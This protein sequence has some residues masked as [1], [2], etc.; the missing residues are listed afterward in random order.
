MTIRA[1]L[2]SELIKSVYKT[3]SR[4]FTLDKYAKNEQ[5]LFLNT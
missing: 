3:T 5:D 2:Q 1:K 4:Q